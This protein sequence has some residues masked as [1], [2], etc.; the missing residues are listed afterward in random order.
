MQVENNP[1]SAQVTRIVDSSTG[2]LV[3]SAA[4]LAGGC[5]DAKHVVL[6]DG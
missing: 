2:K 6:S 1:L 3:L 4:T 5:S